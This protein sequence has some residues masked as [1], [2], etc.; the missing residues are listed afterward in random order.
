MMR[1]ESVEFDMKG[2]TVETMILYGN[3]IFIVKMLEY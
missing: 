3:D 1:V 2:F